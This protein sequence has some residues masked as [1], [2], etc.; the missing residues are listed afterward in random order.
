[1]IMMISAMGIF[2]RLSDELQELA[3]VQTGDHVH[4]GR[5]QDTILEGSQVGYWLF[6]FASTNNIPFDT[7]APHIALLTG[8]TAGYNEARIIELRQECLSQLALQEPASIQQGLSLGFSFIGWA[9]A[10]AGIEPFAPTSFDLE[11]M[12]RKGLVH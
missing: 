1:M 10:E 3:D 5:Q 6:L 7:F 4:T 11:Q 9:C 2:C 8:Y 12:R